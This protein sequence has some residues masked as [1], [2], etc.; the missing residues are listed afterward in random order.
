MPRESANRV[1]VGIW[2]LVALLGAVIFATLRPQPLSNDSY[3]YLTVAK[4]IGERHRIETS[5]VHFDSERSHNRIPAPLTTFPPG[6]PAAIAAIGTVAPNL[7]VAAR[8]VSVLSFALTVGLLSWALFFLRVPFFARQCLLL[9]LLTNFTTASF[10]ISVLSEPLFTAILLGAIVLLIR[11]FSADRQTWFSLGLPLAAIGVAYLVRYAGLLLVPPVCGYALWL[12]W[13]RRSPRTLYLALGLPLATVVPIS[14]R[15]WILTGDWK[16]GDELTFY[17]PPLEVAKEYVRAQIHLLLGGH[18]V[19]VGLWEVLLTMGFLGLVVVAVRNQNT[20]ARAGNHD[21]AL[22]WLGV[23]VFFYTGAMGYLGVKSAISFG[24]RMFQPM[25]PL[26]LCLAG[27]ALRWIAARVPAMQWQT[28]LT[29]MTLG[30]VGANAQDLRIP[31]QSGLDV[32]L[33]SVFSESLPSGTNLREWVRA[34]VPPNV[35]ILAADGQATGFVLDRPVVSLLE[36]RYTNRRWD[37]GTITKTL[38]LFH[39]RYVL[40]YQQGVNPGLRLAEESEFVRE[41]LQGSPPCRYQRVAETAD[42]VILSKPEDR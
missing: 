30:F 18:A 37:C 16:G 20:Q 17:N 14:L 3:Q 12:L 41:A 34:S 8:A 38:E 6:Y 25:V 31:A 40:L 1:E 4:A 26:Y 36:S 23:C 35:P 13:K 2:A 10:A 39:A 5:L 27:L 19:G 33:Q 21:G 24:P 28:L 15:N 32:R 29:L 7:E 22:R 11:S 9:L 42:A